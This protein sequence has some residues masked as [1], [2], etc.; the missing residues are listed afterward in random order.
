MA[1]GL[2]N[3]ESRNNSKGFVGLQDAG[4]LGCV[5]GIRV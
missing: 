2:E 3:S 5:L 4:C 1:T